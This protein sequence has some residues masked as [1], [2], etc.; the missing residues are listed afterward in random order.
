MTNET[1]SITEPI[2]GFSDNPL[3]IVRVIAGLAAQYAS[4]NHPERRSQPSPVRPD[5]PIVR[6]AQRLCTIHGYAQDGNELPGFMERAARN[7]LSI[8]E[9]LS[10]LPREPDQSDLEE[11][12]AEIRDLNK[13]PR[14][15]YELIYNT[16]AKRAKDAGF[17]SISD[18]IRAAAEA[19]SKSE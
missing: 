5:S 13:K 7:N 17:Q 8:L 18:A 11:A 1:N 2:E 4:M 3:D 9:V 16:M 10:R 15:D 14:V 6:A 12:A 19:K